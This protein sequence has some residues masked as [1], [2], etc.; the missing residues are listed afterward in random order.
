MLDFANLPPG[1]VVSPNPYIFDDTNWNV[2]VSFVITIDENFTGDINTALTL[3]ITSNG[4]DYGNIPPLTL[5]AMNITIE[6]IAPPPPPS[7]NDWHGEF[8]DENRAHAFGMQDN[9]YGTIHMWQG[10]WQYN[11]GGIPQEL[12]D[13]GVIFAVDVWVLTDDGQTQF[14][15]GGYQEICMLGEGRMIFM[16]ATQSPRTMTEILP[17]TFE[18]GYTCGW[19]PNAG[20]VILINP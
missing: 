2:P 5:S 6:L 13:Y 18:D 11:A 15:L 10:A 17:V 19:I 4:S 3:T 20:T 7:L 9:V 8:E 14:D 12:I 16:D 1:I